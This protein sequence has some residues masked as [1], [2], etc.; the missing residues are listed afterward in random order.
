MYE[1]DYRGPE[2]HKSP[3]DQ[4]PYSPVHPKTSLAAPKPKAL[5][6][7]YHKKQEVSL[8]PSYF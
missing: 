7:K 2:T 3:P 4:S 6:G 1:I 8:P 5:K